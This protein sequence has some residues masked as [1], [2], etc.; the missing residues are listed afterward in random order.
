V[1]C[2]L[3][4]GASI[5]SLAGLQDVLRG[6]GVS[7]PDADPRPGSTASGCP[8]SPA[9][10]QVDLQRILAALGVTAPTTQ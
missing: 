3:A 8:I 6:L 9:G 7:V 1:L 4:G 2:S 10:S 5:T